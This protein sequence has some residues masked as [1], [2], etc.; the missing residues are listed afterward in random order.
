[1]TPTWRLPEY[2]I[3]P[4]FDSANSLLLLLTGSLDGNELVSLAQSLMSELSEWEVQNFLID[5]ENQED[6]Y[7]HTH[8]GWC[9]VLVPKWWEGTPEQ[10]LEEINSN[11]RQWISDPN[12]SLE[13]QQRTVWE[14][15]L[16]MWSEHLYHVAD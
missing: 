11:L 14:I 16:G 6:L 15:L 4:F 9:P 12:E 5:L 7:N 2:R 10:F 3:H 13:D 1:M 8:R